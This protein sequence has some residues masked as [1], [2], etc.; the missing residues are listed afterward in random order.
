MAA[1]GTAA[2]G[3]NM[4]RRRHRREAVVGGR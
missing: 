1:A 2:C 4:G 3:K